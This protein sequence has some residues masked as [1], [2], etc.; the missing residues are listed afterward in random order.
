MTASEKKKLREGILKTIGRLSI[1]EFKKS[2][3]YYRANLHIATALCVC[4]FIDAM[5]KYIYGGQADECKFKR[6]IEAYMPDFYKALMDK[7]HREKAPEKEKYLT[8]FYGDVRCG[9]VHEYFPKSKT[10]IMSK[11]CKEVVFGNKQ[12][13]K[14]CLPELIKQWQKGFG[15]AINDV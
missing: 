2:G 13:L 3:K 15:K 5:G 14:I 12:E 8:Q 10:M 7:A 11:K 1:A 6:F 9:L 4:C